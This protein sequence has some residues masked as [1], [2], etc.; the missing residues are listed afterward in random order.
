LAAEPE[1][2]TRMVTQPNSRLG[3]IQAKIDELEYQRE[4]LLQDYK[5]T[6]AKVRSID[7]LLAEMRHRLAQ[8]GAFHKVLVYQPNQSRERLE[9]EIAGLESELQSLKVQRALTQQQLADRR[10]PVN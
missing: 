2:R 6:H 3:M 9:G 4:A 10:R 5:P 8:E 1:E 7:G